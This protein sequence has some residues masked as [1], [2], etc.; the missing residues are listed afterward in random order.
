VIDDYECAVVGGRLVAGSD[1]SDARWVS[2]EQ[3][4]GL[5]LSP[6]LWETLASWGQVSSSTAG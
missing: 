1:A 3:M 6:L 5:S 4:Q 2:E